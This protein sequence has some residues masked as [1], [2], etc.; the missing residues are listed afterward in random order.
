M[1]PVTI[2][3]APDA[4]AANRFDCA[5]YGM[6]RFSSGMSASTISFAPLHRL[7]SGYA[8]SAMSFPDMYLLPR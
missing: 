1:P 2:I 7:S 6:T 4:T 8:L 3:R 5:E